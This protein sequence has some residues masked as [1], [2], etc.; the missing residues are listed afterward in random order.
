MNSCVCLNINCQH[1]VLLQ[2][3]IVAR[4][5]GELIAFCGISL[6]VSATEPHP[7]LKYSIHTLTSTQLLRKI[8][9]F[10]L[11]NRTHILPNVA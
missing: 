3:L 2:N 11:V 5:I 7:E 9:L 4:L 8:P 6:L 1:Q 10:Q